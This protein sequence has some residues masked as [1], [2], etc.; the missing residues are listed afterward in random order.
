MIAL[1]VATPGR[2]LTRSTRFEK[3]AVRASQADRSSPS[4]AHK[5]PGFFCAEQSYVEEMR[6]S[7]ELPEGAALTP[8]PD[9]DQ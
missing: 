9:S 7:L 2:A 6:R 1:T 3:Y 4:L 5:K 8:P